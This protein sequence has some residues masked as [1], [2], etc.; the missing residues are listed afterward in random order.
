M[1][2][3]IVCFACGLS[4]TDIE[5]GR[6]AF[7]EADD[8]TNTLVMVPVTETMLSW[9][10][11]EAADDVIGR[12]HEGD[13]VNGSVALNVP[14]EPSGGY[15]MVMIDCQDNARV[16]RIMRSFKSVLSAPQEIIFAVITDTARTWNF[17]EYS[18]QLSAEH[19]YMKTRAPT[20]NPDMKKMK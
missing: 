18:A 7:Y 4:G 19:E 16:I 8:G 12:L 15:R 5:K 20:E 1:N 10:V 17:D 11:G 2:H 9:N 6:A 3:T 14:E 13:A